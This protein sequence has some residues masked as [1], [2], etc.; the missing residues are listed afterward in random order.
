[1]SLVFSL[2]AF[3]LDSLDFVHELHQ[4]ATLKFLSLDG[5]DNFFCISLSF[6]LFA[7]VVVA[8]SAPS[9]LRKKVLQIDVRT[10]RSKLVIFAA[11]SRHAPLA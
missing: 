9:R 5:A 4:I 11:R 2:D 3:R 8:G 10:S 1:M 6:T 7:C